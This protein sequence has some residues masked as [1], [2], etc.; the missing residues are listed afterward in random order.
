[1][2]APHDLD[3]RGDYHPPVETPVVEQ[4]EYNVSKKVVEYSFAAIFLIIG[5]VGVSHGVE[6][7]GWAIFL[8][9]VVGW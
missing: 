7:A 2:S 1:M 9:I 6:Y 4:E 8:A 5:L 3:K